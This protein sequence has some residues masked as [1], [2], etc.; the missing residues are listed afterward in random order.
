MAQLDMYSLKAPLRDKQQ[1]KF[2]YCTRCSGEMYY[3]C[4]DDMPEDGICEGCKSE[5]AQNF[6]TV[7]APCSICG[8]W[9]DADFILW[10]SVCESCQER[11]ERYDGEESA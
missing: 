2:L 8:C 11:M 6:D 4:A 7:G 1:D 10:E 3:T 9:I 5:D